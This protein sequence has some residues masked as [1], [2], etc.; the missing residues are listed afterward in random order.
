MSQP[1][2]TLLASLNRELKEWLQT[3]PERHERGAIVL[4]RRLSRPVAEL[5]GSDRFLAIE[6]IKMTEDW[7]LDSSERHF[8]INMRKLPEIYF[9]CENENLVLGFAHN[10]PNG[11]LKFSIQDDI[12]EKNILHGLSGC[13]GQ[14]VFLVSMLL[15]GDA[16]AARVRQGV[17]PDRKTPVRHLSI[18]GSNIE[19]FGINI[20]EAL[21]ETLVRQEAA[22]GKPFNAKLQSLRVAVVGLGGTG[23]PVATLLARTGIGELI[24]IDGDKLEGSNMNRVR[25]YVKDDIGKNKAESLSAFIKSLNLDVKVVAYPYYLTDSGEAIDALSSADVIFGCTDDIAGR[26]LMNQALYYYGQVYVDLGLSGNVENDEDGVP[27]LRSQKSRVSCILPEDGKC[28][29]CQDVINAQKLSNE[30]KFKANP[31][32]RNLDSET[33]ERDYYIIGGGVQSPGIG[34]FTSATADNAV[35]T[36]MNLVRN[37]RKLPSDL[38]QDNIW[39]DFRH[40]NIHSNLPKDNVECIYCSKGL[41]LL[42]EEKKYRLDIPRLG[43]FKNYD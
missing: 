34:A 16:W 39:I 11:V 37:F 36:L 19:L 30:E 9:R 35:A 5:P 13:N 18:L 41:L 8:T 4:F 26:D 3:H 28:L 29:E 31:E 14:N 12:N 33:L 23:S 27:I 21:P 1:R 24:L 7:I 40:L 22:F 25:G 10:H 20:P 32:L 42:K 2:I 17:N 38:R 43:A 6:I 15:A